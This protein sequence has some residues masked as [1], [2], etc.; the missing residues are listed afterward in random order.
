[1]LIFLCGLWA[2]AGPASGAEPRTNGL[3]QNLKLKLQTMEFEIART[4]SELPLFPVASLSYTEYG[5]ATFARVEGEGDD[6]AFRSRVAS[7]YAVAPLWI[8]RH[9]LILAV[10]AVSH[11]EFDFT[12]GPYD[13]R[14]VTTLRLALGGAM[15]TAGGTQWGGFVMPSVYSPLTGDGEWTAS[16]M[17]GIFGRHLYKRRTIWYYGLVYDYAFSDGYFLPYLGFTYV[18]NPSWTFSVLLPWP[19]VNYAPSK[20]FFVKLGVVPSGASWSVKDQED[21]AQAVASYGGWDMGLWGSVRLTK[22]LWFALGAGVS[23]LRGLEIDT[24][25][26]TEFDPSFNSDPFVSVALSFRPE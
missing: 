20:H 7:T 9:G 22:G 5:E 26:E 3:V 21:G 17:G 1:V 19:A 8:G 11:T 13:D 14:G 6:A 15:Q 4:Q 12:S 23:G 25:G 18:Q 2:L 24:N 10:P 16:G